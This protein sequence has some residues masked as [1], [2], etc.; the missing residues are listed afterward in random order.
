MIAVGLTLQLDS[1]GLGEKERSAVAQHGGPA[2]QGVAVLLA[3]MVVADRP[4]RVDTE[5]GR[6]PA[7]D[8]ERHDE[9]RYDD[10]EFHPESVLSALCARE[11]H[12][13]G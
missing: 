8:G 3:A 13:T 11:R 6:E 4:P 12:V 10:E 9:H 2:L 7:E 1:P 5:T